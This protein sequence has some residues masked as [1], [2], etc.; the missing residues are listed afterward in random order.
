MTHMGGNGTRATTVF[1]LVI[2]IKQRR[3]TQNDVWSRKSKLGGRRI[4]V[5]SCVYILNPFKS[6]CV[7]MLLLKLVLRTCLQTIS[8]GK[9]YPN[10]TL[11]K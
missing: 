1:S 2:A 4:L 8:A 3:K 6:Y 7:G 5:L 9:Y 10:R 11:G